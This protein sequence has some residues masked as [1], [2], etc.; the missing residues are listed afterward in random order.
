MFCFL[1]WILCVSVSSV[2]QSCSTLCDPMDSKHARLPHPSPTPRACSKSCPSSR[3]CHPTISSSVVPFSSCLQSFPA[4][5]THPL[6]VQ[7]YIYTHEYT[8]THRTHI[9]ITCISVVIYITNSFIAKYV[10]YWFFFLWR[11][12]IQLF[13]AL[14]FFGAQAFYYLS[15]FMTLHSLCLFVCEL[16]FIDNKY[17]QFFSSKWQVHFLHFWAYLPNTQDRIAIMCLSFDIPYK[18]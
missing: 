10:A 6:C 8:Y 18:W 2:T 11:T 13:S 4:S 3:W 12:L 15:P 1:S 9:D 5:G 17:S 14:R 16:N 7:Y